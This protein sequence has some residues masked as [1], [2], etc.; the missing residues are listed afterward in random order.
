[1]CVLLDKV[2]PIHPS[3]MERKPGAWS[4]SWKELLWLA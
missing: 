4:I 1:V 2:T 3:R